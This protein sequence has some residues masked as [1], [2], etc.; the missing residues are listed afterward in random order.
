MRHSVLLILCAVAVTT[1][2]QTTLRVMVYN[3]LAFPDP[4]PVNRQD[5]L[6]KIIAYHPVD[7]LITEEMLSE[8]GADLVL[9]EALNVNGTTSFSRA[10]FVVQLSDPN[11]PYKLM[12]TLFY[13]HERFTLKEQRTLTTSVRDINVFKLY[14]NDVDLAQTMDTTFLTIYAVHLKASQGVVNEYDRQ[15]MAEV[16]IDDLITLPPGSNAFVAGD[17]NIY[18]AAEGAYTVLTAT[19]APMNL[20]DPLTLPV[21]WNANGAMAEHHTQSTRTSPLYGEGSGG[22]LDDRFDMALFS[23]A[24]MDG[25]DRLQLVPSSY[26]PLGNSGTCLNDN[27]T[28]CSPLQTPYA[29][30]RAMY[31][32]SDHLPLVFGLS[33]SGTV[34]GVHS[35]AGNDAPVQLTC[36]ESG[37]IRLESDAPGKG[38]LRF[39]DLSG[40]VIYDQQVSYGIG[41][42]S[43]T[44]RAD[45]PSGCYVVQ[46]LT[47]QHT[48]SLRTLLAP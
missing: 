39:V 33:Y 47:E 32:M 6:A 12:Q 5:T 48:V 2:A 28:D 8:A 23:D 24:V 40:R 42:T 11:S 37:T 43:F 3:L 44:A 17:M 10:D 45:M 14:L 46:L 26:L 20:R 38:L 18:S 29:V 34:S 22:G 21:Q 35:F 30:L 7:L 31:Y 36:G 1:S 15:Q 25:T 16:V 4:I 13:D 27:I 41:V 9:N 19:G